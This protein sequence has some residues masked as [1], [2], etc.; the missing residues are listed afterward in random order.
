ME[1][2]PA[3]SHKAREPRVVQPVTTS[4]ARV[5]SAPMG[6]RFRET[7]IKGDARS[8]WT[9]MIW[10]TFFPNL[11]ENFQDA[12]HNGVDALFGGYSTVGRGRNR[13]RYA[14]PGGSSVSK[15]NPDRALGRTSEPRFSDDDRR[16][17]RFEVLEI[18]SRVEAQEV[19]NQ[20][21]LLIDKFDVCSVA[22]FLQ[23][24]QQTP[25]SADYKFGWEELG[26]VS[27]V[28]SRGSYYLDLPDP[29]QL[30]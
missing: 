21:N 1:E 5:R 16:N 8:V 2:F 29:I 17:H 19:L 18:D 11:S 30:R 24:V 22:D 12:I 15:H 13:G 25:T 23:M 4:V 7:F 14:R 3:Q 6:R 20:M 26:N 9:S 27:V 28:S 10:E